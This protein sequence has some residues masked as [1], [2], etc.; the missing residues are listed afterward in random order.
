MASM[1]A[2]L[3]PSRR[4]IQKVRVI[5][6]VEAQ[7]MHTRA[8]H[9]VE[10]ASDA[11]SGSAAIVRTLTRLMSDPLSLN[12]GLKSKCIS[13]GKKKYAPLCPFWPQRVPKQNEWSTNLCY[14]S[15][16][17]L[18]MTL[19]GIKICFNVHVPKNERIEGFSDLNVEGVNCTERLV[20]SDHYSSYF[21]IPRNTR[22]VR[23]WISYQFSMFTYPGIS[24]V[25]LNQNLLMK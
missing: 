22:N 18:Q 19:I 16:N 20:H 25:T 23:K 2:V 14:G 9:S 12:A 24:P 13:S 4:C 3:A 15:I 17:E 11:S 21:K 10:C 5:T 8:I 6:A 7:A 1:D